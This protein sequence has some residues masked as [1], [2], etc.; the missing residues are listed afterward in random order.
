MDLGEQPR[1]E[2]PRQVHG[3]QHQPEGQIMLAHHALRHGRTLGLAGVA[4]E[5][6]S[7]A[8]V[9]C[10]RELLHHLQLLAGCRTRSLGRDAVVGA[11]VLSID[12]G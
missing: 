5:P 4:E 8:L 9:L 1:T 10:F 11:L 3:G 12:A 2:C 7:L 6:C